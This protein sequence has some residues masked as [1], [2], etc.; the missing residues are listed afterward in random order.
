[1]PEH[2]EGF[3]PAQYGHSRL[4]HAGAHAGRVSRGQIDDRQQIRPGPV[5]PADARRDGHPAAGRVRGEV[6]GGHGDRDGGFHQLGAE[7]REHQQF[8]PAVV[9]AGGPPVRQREESGVL[10]EVAAGEAAR[11]G[12]VRHG[13]HMDVSFHVVGDEQQGIDGHEC[14]QCRSGR[15]ESGDR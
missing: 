8:A 3:A 5:V 2:D 7:R 6:L 9:D 4:A 15:V 10:G 12:A 14:L 13:Q 11:L 1:M